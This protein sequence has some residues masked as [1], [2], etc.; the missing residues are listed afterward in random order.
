MNPLNNREDDCFAVSFCA[1]PRLERCKAVTT[2]FLFIYFALSIKPSEYFD[3]GKLQS[4]TEAPRGKLVIASETFY[5]S[6]FEIKLRNFVFGS[7]P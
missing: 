7:G 2:L 1:V 6:R 3:G 4:K 5:R